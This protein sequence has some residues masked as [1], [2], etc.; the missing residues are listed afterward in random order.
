[1]FFIEYKQPAHLFAGLWLPSCCLTFSN[2]LRLLIQ[3]RPLCSVDSS[4][5]WIFVTAAGNIRMGSFFDQNWNS[6]AS[7][8]SHRSSCTLNTC[9]FKWRVRLDARHC[10]DRMLCLLFLSIRFNHHAHRTHSLL[11][12]HL[13]DLILDRPIKEKLPNDRGNVI[14]VSFEFSAMHRLISFY[15]PF[16]NVTYAFIQVTW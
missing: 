8:E 6:N 3:N 4:T 13:F 15:F 12:V 2:I 14:H 1:M 16:Q 5:S 9:Y 11:A 10:I 7:A